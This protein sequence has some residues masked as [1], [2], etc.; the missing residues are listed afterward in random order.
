MF[1]EYF[2]IPLTDIYNQS[3]NYKIFPE[4]WKVSNIASVPKVHLCSTVEDLRPIALTSVLSEIQ[5]SYAMDWVLEDIRDRISDSQFGGLAGMSAVTALLFMLHKW[6]QA[7][8]TSKRVIRVT[9]L[10]FRK[11]FDLIDHNRLLENFV[12]IGMRP[13]VI[14][15]YASYLSERSQIALY[16]GVQSERMM[17]HG[18]IP[19]GSKLGPIAFITRRRLGVNL[20]SGYLVDE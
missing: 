13:G 1:P 3:F 6:Y 11:A 12:D 19:Q 18:G 15:W 7:M 10:D 17:S 14:G 5:D 20:G 8:E 2:A 16:Q 4:V 9:F